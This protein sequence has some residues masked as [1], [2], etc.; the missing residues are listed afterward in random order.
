MV[1]GLANGCHP[2]Q[3]LWKPKVGKFRASL[4]VGKQPI[5]HWEGQVVLRK[6]LISV[7]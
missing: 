7:L 1:V 3:S 4:G 6:E 2:G 5:L